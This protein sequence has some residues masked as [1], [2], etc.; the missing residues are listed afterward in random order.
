MPVRFVRAL[1]CLPGS[2]TNAGC[3]SPARFDVLAHDPY[4]VR[5]PFSPA[6]NADDVSAPDLHKLTALVRQAVAA[7]TALP[8]KAKRLWVTEFSYDGS[9]PDP[10]GVPEPK[11]AQWMAEA[12]EEFWRQGADAVAWFLIQDQPGPNFD[13]TYQSGIFTSDGLPKL[14]LQT[15]RFPFT[16]RRQRGRVAV[17]GRAPADGT[18]EIQRRDGSRWTTV[19]RLRATADEVFEPNLALKGRPTLRARLGAIASRSYRTRAG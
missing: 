6:L 7:G 1:L 14:A 16:A 15:F 4:S 17:W 18:V 11:R 3:H 19:A 5:G 9:P 2:G 10:H 8:K 13:A 12:F